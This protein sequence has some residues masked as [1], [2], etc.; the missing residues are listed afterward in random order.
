MG[1]GTKDRFICREVDKRMV[2]W[3]GEGGNVEDRWCWWLR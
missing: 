2:K 1:V 3:M